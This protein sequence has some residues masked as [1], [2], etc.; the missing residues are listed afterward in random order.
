MEWKWI[1][2]LLIIIFLCIDIF[3]GVMVYQENRNYMLNP[4]VLLATQDILKSRNLSLTFSLESITTK[5]YMRKIALSGENEMLEKFIPLVGENDYEYRGR[6]RE[7]ISLA[8]AISYFLR[9]FDV[10]D[11]T[12]SSIELGYYPEMSQIDE[13]ILSGEAIP[14]WKI[15]AGEKTY[16]YNAYV[17]SLIE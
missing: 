15:V 4:E 12:I 9:D 7:I 17:G 13:N 5:R 16:L 6:R 2:T 1:K 3:L 14:A 8:S 11:T 10:R